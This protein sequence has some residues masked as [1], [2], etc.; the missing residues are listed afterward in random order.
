M[1]TTTTKLEIGPGFDLQM[2]KGVSLEKMALEKGKLK[3]LQM[4]R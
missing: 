1:L 3:H 4:D 2:N